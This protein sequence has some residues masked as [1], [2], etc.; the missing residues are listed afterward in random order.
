M[1]QITVI[2]KKTSVVQV[3]TENEPHNFSWYINSILVWSIKSGNDKYVS[4]FLLSD[5]YVMSQKT[6]N[7][8]YIEIKNY[9]YATQDWYQ[10]FYDSYTITGLCLP[11]YNAEMYDAFLC[12]SVVLHE[13][14]KFIIAKIS[15]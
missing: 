7:F 4:Y 11:W 1:S 14:I 8:R 2:F 5:V 9:N 15:I 6:I 12:M 3:A 10:A 13:T